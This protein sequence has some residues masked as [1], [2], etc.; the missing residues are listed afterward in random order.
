MLKTETLSHYYRVVKHWLI[1]TMPDTCHVQ[2]ISDHYYPIIKIHQLERGDPMKY[3]PV[4]FVRC[5][6]DKD[7]KDQFLAWFEESRNIILNYVGEMLSEDYKLSLTAD[8][9]NNSFICSITCK[10]ASSPNHNCCFSSRHSDCHTALAL[11][12]YKWLHILPENW[13]TLDDQEFWG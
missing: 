3:T 12:V 4:V 6:L 5:S 9:Q 2:Y 1:L 8:I 10:A 7:Q 13:S 11:A